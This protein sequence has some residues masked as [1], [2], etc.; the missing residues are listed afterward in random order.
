MLPPAPSSPV[1][2]TGR[3]ALGAYAGYTST[4]RWQ[5]LHP[6]DRGKLWTA[7]HEKRWHYMSIAG[8][9]VVVAFAI[10]DVGWATSAFAYVFDRRARQL[11][12]NVTS[13]GL[14]G[15]SAHVSD[16]PGDGARSTF[17]TPFLALEL[18]RPAGSGAWLVHARGTGG[19]AIDATLS[20]TGAPPPLCAV[21]SIEG[22]VAN[23]TH[24]T[25]GLAA[26]GTAVA[27]GTRFEL[28]GC[29]AALDH[30]SGILAR[31]TRWRWASASAPGFGLNLVEGFN[32]P[33]ENAVWLDGDV[34]PVGAAT[35][36]FD[37]AATMAPWTIRTDDGRVDLEFVPEGERREDKNLLV[38]VSRYVQPIGV[39]RGRVQAGGRT[40][41][42]VDI[43]GVTE[44]HVA[45]W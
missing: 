45:R 39:F 24:K 5:G 31:D 43:P 14:P 18:E 16:A 27:G 12:S 8:P 42:V 41:A 13:M 26:S 25:V 21:A 19:L 37:P 35:F 9:E 20:V 36:T 23:C 10:V 22:G 15:V 28:T 40:V 30:T 2:P 11:L 3:P 1:D 34:I 4:T 32:G 44:D 6:A 7:L 17:R 29:T 38:A 33:V